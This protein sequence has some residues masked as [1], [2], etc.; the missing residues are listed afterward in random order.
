MNRNTKTGAPGD[1]TSGAGNFEKTIANNPHIV[2][3][4]GFEDRLYLWEASALITAEPISPN[5]DL[6]IES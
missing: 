3:P 1:K 5:L 6:E 2:S 4:L